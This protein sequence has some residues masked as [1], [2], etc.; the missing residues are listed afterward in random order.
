[1]NRFALVLPLFVLGCQ[2]GHLYTTSGDY[3]VAI[4]ED[5]DCIDIDMKGYTFQAPFTL[6]VYFFANEEDQGA[7]YPLMA[8]PGAFAI[9]QDADGYFVA[10]STDDTSG[11]V[12]LTSAQPIMDGGYHHVALSYDAE[13][14]GQLFLDGQKLSNASVDL[15]GTP[16]EH[17]H[18]GC[19]PGQ[20]AYFSGILGEIRLSS[21]ARYAS[22]FEPN[23][24]EYEVREDT[25]GLWH[26]NEGE[27]DS[28]LDETGS[29]DGTLTGCEWVSF[30]LDGTQP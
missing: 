20:E 18:L 27:Y 12:A 21:S 7:I 4:Y 26:L 19:W 11:S 30:I 9:Y 16:G 24:T 8:W 14:E 17:L 10:G 15:V 1:M 6:E 22:S 13:G 23:W 5:P 29:W 2:P 25:V 28:V 3:G